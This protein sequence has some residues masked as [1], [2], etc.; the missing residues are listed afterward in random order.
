[1]K[2]VECGIRREGSCFQMGDPGVGFCADRISQGLR[3]RLVVQEAWSRE[4]GPDV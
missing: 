2:E 1:M 3:G 4:G